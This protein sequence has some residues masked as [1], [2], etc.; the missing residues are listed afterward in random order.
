[1][2]P[3]RILRPRDTQEHS[4]YISRIALLVAMLPISELLKELES[5]YAAALHDVDGVESA[6]DSNLA[7][8]LA[9][10]RQTQ[11]FQWAIHEAAPSMKPK[12]FVWPPRS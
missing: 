9:I 3:R 7:R 8:E 5:E 1:M 10:V 12:R 6:V 4:R 11:V 2:S